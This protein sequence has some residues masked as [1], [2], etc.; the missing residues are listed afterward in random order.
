MPPRGK[1]KYSFEQW[2]ACRVDFVTGKGSAR[3]CAQKNGINYR[4]VLTRCYKED[5]VKQ[6]DSWFR[7]KKLRESIPVVA[8]AL[9]PPQYHG[10]V[11]MPQPLSRDFFLHHANKHHAN[12][13]PIAEQI[14][15]NWKM[16]NGDEDGTLSVEQRTAVIR[17]TRELISLQRQLLGIP[18]VAPIRRP[19]GEDRRNKG[20]DMG[21]VDL[22]QLRS[23]NASEIQDAQEGHE[24]VG[25]EDADG[26]AEEVRVQVARPATRQPKSGGAGPP[27]FP[28]RK[29]N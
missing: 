25:E 11:P 26:Q 12:L 24:E 21:D 23:A 9:S 29:E 13:D 4:M 8:A 5:W 1:S 16:L 6:R 10:D 22:T 15:K 2:E 20:R 14:A 28:F 27:R 17:E 3:W 7:E 19:S 18:N